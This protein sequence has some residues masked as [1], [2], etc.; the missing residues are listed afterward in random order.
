MSKF[1]R[2]LTDQRGEFSRD[3]LWTDFWK[4]FPNVLYNQVYPFDRENSSLSFG[5]RSS[6]LACS[7]EDRDVRDQSWSRWPGPG[8]GPKIETLPGPGPGPKSETIWYT[9]SP[10]SIRTPTYFF[11]IS[12]FAKQKQEILFFLFS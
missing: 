3:I 10:K 11:R 5:A 9:G 8:P 2:S 6:S 4:H 7:V 1:D 12:W